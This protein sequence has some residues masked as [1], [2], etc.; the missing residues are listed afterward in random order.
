MILLAENKN[1]KEIVEIRERL[2]RL[3]AKN[4]D[5]SRRIESLAEYSKKLYEYLSQIRNKAT[6]F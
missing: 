1:D 3:E 4:E 6:L 5:L 2:A